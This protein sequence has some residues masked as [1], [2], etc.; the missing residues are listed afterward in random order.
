MKAVSIDIVFDTICPWC[1]IGKRRLER[2]LAQRPQLT[3]ALRWRPFLLN[4]DMPAQGIDRRTYL[5]RK[6]GGEH[7]LHRVLAAV[8]GAGRNEHIPFDLEAIR[9]TPSSVE[10]HRMVRHAE[11][12]GLASDAVEALFQA[13]FT[14][15][16]DIGSVPELLAIGRRIG[17][18]STALEA[19]LTDPRDQ[20]AIHAENA[21]AHRLG[22][23]GVPSFLFNDNYAISGAQEPDIFLRLIDL[24]AEESAVPAPVS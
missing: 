1:Y 21:R 12:Q 20:G 9:R 23:S 3:F 16:R 5:E 14:Q 4:P 19:Y 22:V 15:G 17:L 7:R 10:S 24:A 18:E 6:F 11:T 8:S 13:F 2:A